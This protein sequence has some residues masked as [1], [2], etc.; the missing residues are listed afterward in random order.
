MSAQHHKIIESKYV[1]REGVN[2]GNPR[3]NEFGSNFFL[4]GQSTC[5]RA[6]QE[7]DGCLKNSED[8]GFCFEHYLLGL[9]TWSEWISE[10]HAEVEHLVREF[11]LPICSFL[12]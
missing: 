2:L 8:G 10:S 7:G 6:A 1:R 11:E 5:A 3:E 9:R 12:E 4:L